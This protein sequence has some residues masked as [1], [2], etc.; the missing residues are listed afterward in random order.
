MIKAFVKNL[1]TLPGY[2]E[3][4]VTFLDEQE[5]ETISSNYVRLKKG[6]STPVGN[7]DD[8]EEVYII[9][10]GRARLQLDAA[11]SEVGVGDVVYIPRDV[12]HQATCISEEDFEYICVANWPDRLPKLPL[13]SE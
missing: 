6:L 2:N 7:H 13:H 1:T 10:G 9:I 3:E 11:F 12:E 4:G 8:E 5:A